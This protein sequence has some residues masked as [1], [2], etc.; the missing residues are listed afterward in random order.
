LSS[1]AVG[2]EAQLETDAPMCVDPKSIERAREGDRLARHDAGQAL[3]GSRVLYSHDELG[4]VDGELIGE[5]TRVQEKFG[6]GRL[7]HAPLLAAEP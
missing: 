2:A 6:R 1:V 7:V 3:H 5:P 4:C